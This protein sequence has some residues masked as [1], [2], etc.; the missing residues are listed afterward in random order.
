MALNNHDQAKIREY[1][2]GKLSD[3]E[4]QKIEEMLMLDDELFQEL[5]VSKG[6]LVDEYCAGELGPNEQQWLERHYLATP[7]GNER[8]LFAV[9]L[10][11]L[12]RPKLAQKSTN[13]FDRIAAFFRQKPWVIGLVA[14]SV[15]LV[16]LVGVWVSTTAPRNSLAVTLTNSTIKRSTNEAQ[17]HKVAVKPDVGELRIS[18]TLPESVT[19]ATKYRAELDNRFETKSLTPV[20]LEGN[21]VLVVIPAAQV[22]T[23]LY[24]LTLY[25]IQNDG[26]EQAVPGQ[27]FF[28]V[29]RTSP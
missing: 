28:E 11:S 2:L 1:L 6:E 9:A 21:S 4:Q 26:S 27:Y 20:G 15:L 22:P 8:R 17:Y 14:A 3:A 18:L 16:V 5:E 25:A 7:E 12:D 13:I 10:G 19:R 29:V 23:G 24:A